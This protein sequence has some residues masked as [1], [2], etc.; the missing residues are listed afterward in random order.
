MA[1]RILRVSEG[2]AAIFGY[3]S[4]LSQKSMEATLGRNYDGEMVACRLDGWRRTWDIA[5]PNQQFFTETEQGRVY[6]ENILYLNIGPDPLCSMNG[7]AFVVRADDV[8]GFD[9]REWIYDRI[10]ISSQV[11]DIRLSSE[12]WA[13]VGKP[14]YRMTGEQDF[15]KA[16]VR[17][18]YLAIVEEG[19][20]SWDD[21]FRTQYRRSTDPVPTRLVIADHR[22][23]ASG[24]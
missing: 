3:G 19:L 15:H 8:A 14:E 1:E 4:L 6:P 10:D 9:K 17:A 7:V 16:A 24:T 2:Q 18:S 22:Q 5:M 12:L 23:A 20:A 21:E 13:Y 11:R